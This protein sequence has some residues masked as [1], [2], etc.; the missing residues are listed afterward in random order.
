MGCSLPINEMAPDDF[1]RDLAAG[2]IWL[3]A[4]CEPSPSYATG[5]VSR[6]SCIGM[7]NVVRCTCREPVSNTVDAKNFVLR[8]GVRSGL[9][10]MGMVD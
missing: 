3:M 10:S 7:V 4:A 1:P 9:G 8:K 5:R 2:V 6:V